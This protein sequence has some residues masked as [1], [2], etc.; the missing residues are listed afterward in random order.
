MIHHSEINAP[1]RT[2]DVNI[3]K[4]VNI[5]EP[6]VQ[7]KTEPNNAEEAPDPTDS[8][9]Q[10]MQNPAEPEIQII[11][12]SETV[13]QTQPL[14]QPQVKQNVPESP[15][16]QEH[17]SFFEN[18]GLFENSTT[19]A[20]IGECTISVSSNTSNSS[21]STTTKTTEIN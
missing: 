12:D 21:T 3:S 17:R 2:V 18:I 6:L 16:K 4:P 20:K 19:V 11:E 10:F 14:P 1:N 8:D 9:L 13:P 7:I 15:V 5:L